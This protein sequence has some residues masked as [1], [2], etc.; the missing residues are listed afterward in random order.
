MKR[1][2]TMLGF[3]GLWVAALPLLAETGTVGDCTYNYIDNGDGTV[4]LSRYDA[5]GD[6]VDEPISPSPVGE[7]TV[8][9][10]ID[11]KRVVAIGD[12]VFDAYYGM[13]SL[14]IPA[15]VTNMTVDAVLYSYNL[16]N[17]T[18]ATENA[19]YKSVDGILYTKDG[20]TLVACPRAK[21]GDISIA[22]GT[23]RIGPYAFY[24]NNA[25]IAVAIPDGVKVIGYS[26]FNFCYNLTGVTLSASLKVIEDNAFVNCSNESF[27][28]VTIPAGVVSIGAQAF[29][30]CSYLAT[31]TF[32]GVEGDVEIADTAFIATPYDGAKPFSLIV[33]EWGNL[34]GIHGTAPENLALADY[35]NGQELTRIAD[36]ALS[37][38]IYNTA[39]TT[40][41]VVPEGVTWIGYSAFASDAALASVTLPNTLQSIS[42][43]AFTDCTSLRAIRIPPAVTYVD[44]NA[45]YGCTNLTVYAPSTLGDTCSVPEE[46]GCKIEYY[47]LPECTVTFDA[48][49]GT[50]NGEA[51]AEVVVLQGRTLDNWPMPYREGY[52]FAG[53]FDPDGKR[54]RYNFVVAEDVTFTARWLA[55]S[56]WYRETCYLGEEDEQIGVA[57]IGADRTVVTNGVLTIPAILTALNDNGEEVEMPVVGIRSYAF[58]EWDQVDSLVLPE[59]VKMVE[60]YAFG[61]CSSLTNVTFLGNRDLIDMNIRYA[62]AQT[63]WLDAQPFTWMTSEEDG[64]V[65]LDGFYGSPVPDDTLVIPAD[66]T[67]IRPSALPYWYTVSDGDGYRRFLG[68]YT[69]AEGGVQV[70]AGRWNGE[71][72]EIAGG[73]TLYARWEA[74]EPEWSFDVEDGQA[75]IWGNAVLLVGDVAIPASVTVEEDDGDGNVTDVP[76]PVVAIAEDAFCD[77]EITSVTIPASVTNIGDWAF[78]DCA[79]LTNVVFVGGMAGIE[80]RV[81]S[82]F[83]GTPWLE[84]YLASLPAPENDDQADAVQIAGASGR[85]T[86]TNMGA[87]IEDGEPLFDF[88]DSTATVWW[89][90]TAPT[91]GP[92]MFTTQGS[93]FDTVMGVYTGTTVDSLVTVVED[94]DEGPD[95]TSA[96]VFDAV[97][98]TTY[99][100]C[101]G[102]YAEHVG[103]IVL[104]WNVDKGVIVKAGDNIV[105]ENGDG[106][107]TVTAPV[108]GELTEDDVDGIEVKARLDGEWVYTTD[109]YD[110][111]FDGG[112]ITVSL[113]KPEVDTDVDPAAKDPDDKSGFLVDPDMVFVAAEPDVGEGETLGA[114]PVKAVPG[115]WYRASWGDSLHGMTTG[116]AVQADDAELCLGVIRQDGASGFY[117]VSVS[118]HA[119]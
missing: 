98:G 35:L 106:S 51:I 70:D 56:P 84:A 82:A 39:S 24:N 81:A 115:L 6:W 47:E 30:D 67:A 58:E 90:W 42:Y 17:I 101:V 20:K 26:A 1:L 54:M 80:M 93:S 104:S 118:D 111:V 108:G 8:P 25:L 44:D 12:R 14:I 3:A 29:G 64:E 41:I 109:G 107:Y 57:V 78:E 116:E 100:I 40:N 97:A 83:Y 68:W 79:N 55:V 85:A 113:K 61:R 38:E 27:T 92:F 13:T 110:V 60:G 114:L 94:D 15:S 36:N 87:G 73:T 33:D 112:V 34:V 62:F 63:P 9:E 19:V 76:Y 52:D 96:V 45:F 37:A 10:M 72:V 18:V 66:V 16:T 43:G 95:S 22:V 65:Y 2:M 46:D 11:G 50:A 59:S 31:V 89:R 21:G 77:T 23:E 71:V 69:A 86:G 4:T 99:Y 103:D 74:A 102:G 88:A 28:S 119:Q 7:F 75:I 117:K 49:G 91:S 48:N 5:D 105:A 53:W 32:A